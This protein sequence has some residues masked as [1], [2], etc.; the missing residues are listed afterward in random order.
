MT[1]C[2]TIMKR[3]IH[4]L[5]STVY[6]VPVNNDSIDRFPSIEPRVPKQPIINIKLCKRK[7]VSRFTLIG[8]IN[9]A[10]TI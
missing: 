8:S 2:E 6:F 5:M 3:I 1:V 10:K 9:F 7:F 4:W